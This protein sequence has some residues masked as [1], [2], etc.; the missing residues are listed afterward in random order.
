METDLECPTKKEVFFR[1]SN[2]N[3]EEAEAAVVEVRY[4]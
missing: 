1:S 4:R 2:I 3:V